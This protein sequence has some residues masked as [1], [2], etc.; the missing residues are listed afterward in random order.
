MT[1]LDARRVVK[2]VMLPLALGVCCLLSVSHLNVP[3][4]MA[5]VVG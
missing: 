5:Q 3:P 2:P 4:A 1:V